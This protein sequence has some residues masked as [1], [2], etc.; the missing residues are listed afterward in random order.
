MKH[1]KENSTPLQLYKA[2]NNTG[3]TGYVLASSLK[4]AK[5]MVLKHYGVTLKKAFIFNVEPVEGVMLAECQ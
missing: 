2:G 1:L 3:Y 4:E 5:Y